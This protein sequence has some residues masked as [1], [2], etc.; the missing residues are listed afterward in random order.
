MNVHRRGM[1]LRSPG[2]GAHELIACYDL[3]WSAVKL[4]EDEGEGSF[5]PPRG[6]PRHQTMRRNDVTKARYVSLSVSIV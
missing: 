3:L 5:A 1:A 6:S 4:G 2:D